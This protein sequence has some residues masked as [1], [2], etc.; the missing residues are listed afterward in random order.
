MNISEEG[1]VDPQTSRMIEDSPIKY[2]V[3]YVAKKGRTLRMRFY[4]ERNGSV[5]LT[6]EKEGAGR[7]NQN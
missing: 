6:V 7:E 3:L 5:M 1:F 2:L 4:T